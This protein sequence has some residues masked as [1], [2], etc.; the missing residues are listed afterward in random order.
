MQ[1]Y[2]LWYILLSCPDGRP[3]AITNNF[4][5]VKCVARVSVQ[6][7]QLVRALVSCL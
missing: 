2:Y 4:K 3:D 6:V 1:D 5:S 7:A